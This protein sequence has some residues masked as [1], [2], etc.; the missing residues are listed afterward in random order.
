VAKHSRARL[1]T[2]WRSVKWPTSPLDECRPTLL[3][4]QGAA[5]GCRRKCQACGSA[6]ESRLG[7]GAG[8]SEA[9]PP[10]NRTATGGFERLTAREKHGRASSTA[11]A[12]GKKLRRLTAARWHRK[13]RDSSPQMNAAGRPTTW[14]RANASARVRSNPP[15][16]LDEAKREHPPPSWRGW[17][18]PTSDNHR[19]RGRIG[20]GDD[21]KAIARCSCQGE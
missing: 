9:T 20:R 11:Q 2:C 14:Q 6:R 13:R 3:P 19:R 15:T 16:K 10:P 17:T 18:A 4:L 5:G 7:M 12:R 8:C 21:A 1:R